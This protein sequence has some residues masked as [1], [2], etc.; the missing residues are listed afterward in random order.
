MTGEVLSHGIL[1]PN[2]MKCCCVTLSWMPHTLR[3]SC[4]LCYPIRSSSS[5]H[6]TWYGNT[7]CISM[8]IRCNRIFHS[9]T[10]TNIIFKIYDYGQHEDK[11]H[12]SSQKYAFFLTFWCTRVF[13][14]LYTKSKYIFVTVKMYF[15]C[16]WEILG[17]LW[18]LYTEICLMVKIIMPQERF[19]NHLSH[20]K[21]EVRKKVPG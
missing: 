8:L 5:C 18:S 11:Y 15:I 14:A 19:K 6:G 2:T 7:T 16:V 4:N 12:I 20:V 10:L 3:H 17:L 9:V 21:A 1:F 13:E